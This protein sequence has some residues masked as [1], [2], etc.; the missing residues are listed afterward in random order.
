MLKNENI[1]KPL[2]SDTTFCR[3]VLVFLLP[4]VKG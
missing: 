2:S 4:R 3:I 1:D